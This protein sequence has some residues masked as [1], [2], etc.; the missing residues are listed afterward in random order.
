[1]KCIVKIYNKD[2]IKN[3]VSIFAFKPQKVIFLYDKERTPQKDLNN[4]KSACQ[5]RI[6]KIIFESIPIEFHSIDKICRIC[7]R[8]INRNPDCFFDITGTR[9]VS[10]IA[11]YLACKKSF[12]PIFSID[13]ANK[14][15]INIYGCNYLV[16]GFILPKMSIESLFRCHGVSITGSNHPKPVADMYA[17]ILKFCDFIFN[18]ISKW[19][20]VCFFLQN[21]LGAISTEY[22]PMQFVSK[23]HIKNPHFNI[24]LKD[25]SILSL[26]E[27][28]G[29]LRNLYIDDE[30]VTFSFKN[31]IT[32]KYMTD[33]GTWLE[34]YTFIKIQQAPM[35]NDARISTKINW[36]TKQKNINEITNEIDVTFF[37]G[38]RPVF[39]SCKL[40]EPSSDALQELSVYSNYLGGKYSKCILVTLSTIKKERAHILVRAEDMNISIIDGRSIH[41]G[42]FID[43][44]K[45]ALDI[46]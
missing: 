6:N 24:S 30:N 5:T 16:D 39:I 38:I 37:Y 12:T 27:Q 21:A 29:F 40:A 42:T 31:D 43:K 18:D 14:K 25:T 20:E 17:N 45:E 9:E 15:L 10:T 34:L 26:A 36:D 4:L 11:M 28:L 2:A 46:Y 33:F 7:K 3:L 44:I 8:I 32:K 41:D 1:M 19:K 23:R 35:F 13:M 22:K